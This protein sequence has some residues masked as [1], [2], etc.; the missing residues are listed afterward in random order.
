MPMIMY[1]STN[2]AIFVQKVIDRIVQ[3]KCLWLENLKMQIHIYIHL[4]IE[5]LN[6]DE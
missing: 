4:D 3:K 2:T 5:H 6:G 1:K